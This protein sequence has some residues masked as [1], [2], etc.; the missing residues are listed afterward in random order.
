[1][2]IFANDAGAWG[3]RSMLGSLRRWTNHATNRFPRWSS[4]EVTGGKGK[5]TATEAARLSCLEA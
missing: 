2:A 5:G 3:V 1:M 4:T